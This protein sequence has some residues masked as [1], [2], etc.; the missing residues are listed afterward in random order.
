MADILVVD[1]DPSIARAFER[2]LKYDRHEFRIASSAEA[3]LR[4][5]EERVPNLVFMDV[6]MP[7]L[8]GLQALP[9]MRAKYPS[10]DIVIMTAH[11][12]SQTSI[13]AM[14]AGAFDLLAKPLDVEVLRAII[15]KVTAAQSV[16][17]KVA[18]NA[19]VPADETP[20]LVG[21]T[22]AMLDVF[23]LIGRLSTLDVPALVVGE[24]G[25]GKRSIVAAIHEN[26]PRHDQPL[27]LIDCHGPDASA[28]V[29]RLCDGTISGTVHL[30]RVEAL[31]LRD[32]LRLAAMMR[33]RAGAM[34][35]RLI[36]SSEFD[37]SMLTEQGEFSREFYD[38][39]ALITLRLPPLRERR[40]DIPRLVEVLLRRLSRETGRVIQGV[41]STVAKMFR[42]HS[43]PANISE[44][45]SVIRRAGI[46]SSTGIISAWD[47]GDALT[48]RRQSVRRTGDSTLAKATREALRERIAAGIEPDG[49]AYH[50]VVTIVEETM[51]AEALDITGGNQVKA[52]ELL[53]VNRTTLRKKASVSD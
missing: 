50:D 27:R 48:A 20:A 52:A 2:F 35:M 22:P 19:V 13:D 23:K 39:L 11:G 32:Q 37:L 4:M 44:L 49:S 47:L 7:G 41:D 25:T 18:A 8:D 46:L 31:V 1:D 53:G 29:Q 24:R 5:L 21:E 15:Q 38:E 43:W 10:A 45:A 33:E 17:A 16:R 42:E 12:T 40:D 34:P 3:G 51:V 6:R 28:E 30:I 14:R 26:S 9:T 36:G